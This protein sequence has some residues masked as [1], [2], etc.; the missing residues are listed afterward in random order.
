MRPEEF[1]AESV[2]DALPAGAS[3]RWLGTAGFELRY[4]GHVLLIDP[5]VTRV[6][7]W[8]YVTSRIGPDETRIAAAFDRVDAIIVGHSHFDHLMDVP[9]IAKRTGALVIGSSS[10]TNLC[11]IEGVPESQ[12]RECAGHTDLEVGPFRVHLT[13]SVHSEFALGGKV[14]YAGEIPCSCDFGHRGRDYR[15]GDVFGIHIEF[16]GK[17]LYHLGSANLLDD[18]IRAAQVDI[19]MMCLAGR[20][21]TERFIPRALKR[22]QP[23]VVVPM[24]HDNFFRPADSA[25]H[26]LPLVRFGRFVDETMGFDRQI[27]ICALPVGGTLQPA[28]DG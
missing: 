16:A 9:A 4:A 11:R 13:P 20:H 17:S 2:E 3:L 26:L 28:I 14:P 22:L 1:Y 24:H 27:S 5:Y 7:L 19:L 12:L 23:R 8:R 18:E 6:G 10:T 21:A 15:C 25:L